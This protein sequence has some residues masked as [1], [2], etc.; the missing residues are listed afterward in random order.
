VNAALTEREFQ[1]NDSRGA[2]VLRLTTRGSPRISS[3]G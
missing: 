2:A 3:H 1:A